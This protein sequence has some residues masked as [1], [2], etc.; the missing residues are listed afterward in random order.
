M[1]IPA[2]GTG[3]VALGLYIIFQ[4]FFVNEPPLLRSDAVFH[5]GCY[6]PDYTN[7]HSLELSRRLMQ[8][9][10]KANADI[11]LSMYHSVALAPDFED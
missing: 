8:I 2:L 3:V 7:N 11:K 4:H 6:D 9:D 1:F 10:E 5:I